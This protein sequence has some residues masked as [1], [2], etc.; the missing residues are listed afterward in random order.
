MSGRR[1]RVKKRQRVLFTD[2]DENMQ[3]PSPPPSETTSTIPCSSP[4]QIGPPKRFGTTLLAL[5][6]PADAQ[7]EEL[8]DFFS[9]VGK[10]KDFEFHYDH[11]HH[12]MCTASVEYEREQDAFNAADQLH[13]QRFHGHL[14][15]I[16]PLSSLSKK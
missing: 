13:S 3:S 11:H 6:L 7:Y 4:A 12:F 1:G 5:N 8:Q 2:T 16:I 9:S 15:Q 10:V 14:L